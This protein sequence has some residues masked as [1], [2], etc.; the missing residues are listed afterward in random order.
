MKE[1]QHPIDRLFA[2][3]LKG[4]EQAPRPQAWAKLE[5][6]L[7]GQRRRRIGAWWFA[8]AASVAVVVLAGWWAFRDNTPAT[9]LAEQ[10]I[11][12]GAL[13]P[14]KSPTTQD[15]AQVDKV[16][17]TLVKIAQKAEKTDP[18]TQQSSRVGTKPPQNSAPQVHQPV[19]EKSLA[20]Q[21]AQQPTL[22]NKLPTPPTTKID[23]GK[24]LDKPQVQT[25]PVVAAAEAK[26]STPLPLEGN[27]TIVM[28]MNESLVK[29]AFKE[30]ITDTAKAKK[31][32]KLVRLFKQLKNAKDG[33]KVD[34]KEVGFD[35]T[36]LL[37]RAD[38]K[39][40]SEPRRK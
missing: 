35:P 7:G 18:A 19:L 21:L 38:E 33:E 9:Q 13:K 15:F 20:P 4:A 36:K 3:K 26:P 22:D 1:Q 39:W 23:E 14:Q 27:T 2:E 29:N 6:Q 11:K 12:T 10:T 30:T 37:A 24:T 31:A 25:L 8:A 34:W 32:S 5:S 17:D 28:N 40:D 16:D